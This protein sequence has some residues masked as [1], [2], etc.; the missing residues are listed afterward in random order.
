MA[1]QPQRQKGATRFLNVMAANV[2][3]SSAARLWLRAE[4]AICHMPNYF[5]RQPGCLLGIPS[6]DYL[7]TGQYAMRL[8]NGACDLSKHSYAPFPKTPHQ[9]GSM[10]ESQRTAASPCRRPRRDLLMRVRTAEPLVGSRHARRTTGNGS[11]DK[12]A[13]L[14]VSLSVVAHPP[15]PGA[16]SSSSARSLMSRTSTS[17]LSDNSWP[18]ATASGPPS[19]SRR[20]S[21]TMPPKRA[22]YSARGLIFIVGIGWN[23][24]T[25]CKRT[26]PT[27]RYVHGG[28]TAPSCATTCDTLGNPRARAITSATSISAYQPHSHPGS[29]GTCS[30]KRHRACDHFVGHEISE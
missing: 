29:G 22:R 7:L 17:Y 5:G 3:A 16:K 4:F 25:S 8:R 10:S 19:V 20:P 14:V 15:T 21:S 11:C 27:T 23:G 9:T 30:G 6:I 28:S 18:N 1:L 24:S 2:T 12:C 13:G 26:L